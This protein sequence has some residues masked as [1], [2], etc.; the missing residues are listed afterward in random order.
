[1]GASIPT[2]AL[3]PYPHFPSPRLFCPPGA[4]AVA[5]AAFWGHN[6]TLQLWETAPP[7]LPSGSGPFPLALIGIHPLAYLPCL[8]VPLAHLFFSSL[9]CASAIPL[10]SCIR[11][12][13]C[14]KNGHQETPQPWEIIPSGFLP[15]SR[16]S[17]SLIGIHLLVRSPPHLLC[18]PGPLA[19]SPATFWA[20][21]NATTMGYYPT[22]L[23]SLLLSDRHLPAHSFL[24][25]FP[26]PTIHIHRQPAAHACMH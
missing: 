25:P 23:P 15:G 17:R 19:I 21:R 14:R 22:R 8:L 2:R 10:T 4:F 9:A 24:S 12:Y 20:L 1:M 6:E 18:Q 26:L 11:H 13:L 16:P 5:P 3:D 7:S